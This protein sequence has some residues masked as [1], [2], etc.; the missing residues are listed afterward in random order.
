MLIYR[1]DQGIDEINPV[2]ILKQLFGFLD[3][4]RIPNSFSFCSNL[5][6]ILKN[7]RKERLERSID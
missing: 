6:G 2:L 3:Q 4:G 7:P 5:A 1:T